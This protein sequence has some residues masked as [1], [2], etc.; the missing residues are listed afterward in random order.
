MASAVI[1]KTNEQD[2]SPQGP[3]VTALQVGELATNR[4]TGKIYIRKDAN[5][6][7]SFK[8]T[9]DLTVDDIAGAAR[10]H[11]ATLTGT[12]TVNGQ[13][14]LKNGDFLTGGTY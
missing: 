14:I 11:N 13:P 7:A 2:G 1:P 9:E 5:Q 10:N 12:P 8:P 4:T 3:A 6:L